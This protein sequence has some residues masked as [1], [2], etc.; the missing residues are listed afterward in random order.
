M[1]FYFCTE[2]EFHP[3]N[4]SRTIQE[5]F[6]CNWS[7]NLILVKNI[8][9][10]LR[11]RYGLHLSDDIIYH[12]TTPRY[13][14]TNLAAEISAGTGSELVHQIRVHVLHEMLALG[15]LEGNMGKEYSLNQCLGLVFPQLRGFYY[16]GEGKGY[17]SEFTMRFAKFNTPKPELLEDVEPEWMDPGQKAVDIFNMLLAKTE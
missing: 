8:P 12:A 7:H 2:R 11:V 17:C 5:T 10:E 13:S 16:N 15:W 14:K 1:E 9:I 6:S 3:D 4:F